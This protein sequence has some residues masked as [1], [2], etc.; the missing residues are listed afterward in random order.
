MM[1]SDSSHIFTS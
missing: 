1:V